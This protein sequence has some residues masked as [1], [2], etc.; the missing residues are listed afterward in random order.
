MQ[1]NEAPLLFGW[2]DQTWMRAFAWAKVR[3]IRVLDASKLTRDQWDALIHVK[4]KWLESGGPEAG[5]Q[6]NIILP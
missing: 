2:D 4:E 3:P 1:Q 5:P 6:G